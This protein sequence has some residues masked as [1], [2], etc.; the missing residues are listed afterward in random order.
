MSGS[1]GSPSITQLRHHCVLTLGVVTGNTAGSANKPETSG[2]EELGMIRAFAAG[3]ELNG[4]GLLPAS[5]ADDSAKSMHVI[6][7]PPRL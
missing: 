7:M 2:E 6:D 4:I 1:A 5:C 3:E